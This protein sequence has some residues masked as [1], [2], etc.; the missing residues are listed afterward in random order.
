MHRMMMTGAALLL[1]GASSAPPEPVTL[2]IMLVGLR[3]S[4]GEVRVCVFPRAD[5]FPDCAK[6]EGVRRVAAPAAPEVRL[7]VEGLTPGAYAVSVI[8]DE[9]GNRK[10]DKSVVG[11]PTEGIGFSRNPRLIFGPPAFDKV[12]FDPSAEPMQAIK[13]RYYL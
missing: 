6:V 13:M 1:M 3:S 10:L 8:H 5:G 2:T 12:R 4:E 11:M 7:T 9:N